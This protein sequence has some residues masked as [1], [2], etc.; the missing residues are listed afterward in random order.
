MFFN[1]LLACNIFNHKFIHIINL[2]YITILQNPFPCG[3]RWIFC[4]CGSKEIEF[5]STFATIQ[6]NSQQNKKT[7]SS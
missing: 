5:I 3:N 4:P 7:L 1:L 2:E 6:C